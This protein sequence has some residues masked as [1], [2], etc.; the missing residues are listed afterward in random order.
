MLIDAKKALSSL[1]VKTSLCLRIYPIL[2]E[3]ELKLSIN[4]YNAKDIP[5]YR[6]K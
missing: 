2:I 5:D 3:T 4:I 1:R 6:S